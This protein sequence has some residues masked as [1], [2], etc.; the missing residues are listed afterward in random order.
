MRSGKLS[1][2][3]T[4]SSGVRQGDVLTPTL[5]NIFLYTVLCKALEGFTGVV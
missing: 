3:F 1:S 5:F 2:E 4:I